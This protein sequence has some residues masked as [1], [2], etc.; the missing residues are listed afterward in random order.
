MTSYGLRMM[1]LDD[2]VCHF[3]LK[4]RIEEFEEKGNHVRRTS[5]SFSRWVCR[6][7]SPPWPH[8]VVVTVGPRHG[9]PWF[10]MFKRCHARTMAQKPYVIWLK[11]HT[12]NCSKNN[13][14]PDF[15]KPPNSC[16][17][18]TSSKLRAIPRNKVYVHIDRI[19]WYHAIQNCVSHACVLSSLSHTTCTLQITQWNYYTTHASTY[20]CHISTPTHIHTL[21]VLISRV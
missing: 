5:K 19:M 7:W 16:A 8:L 3:Q 1:C 2:N 21:H 15:K 9:A 20:K 13:Q 6:W 17:C 12:H 10:Y 11:R 18:Y 14:K 4:I